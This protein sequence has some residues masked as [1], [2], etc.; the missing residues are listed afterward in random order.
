MAQITVQEA[1]NRQVTVEEHWL[2]S[3]INNITSHYKPGDD[4]PEACWSRAFN[5]GLG[6]AV[7]VILDMESN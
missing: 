2:A 4:K 3:I 1:F 6:V 5:E 7:S